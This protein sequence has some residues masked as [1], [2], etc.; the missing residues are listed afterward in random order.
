MANRDITCDVDA[1]AASLEQLIGDIPQA[2]GD[3]TEKAVG[4]SVRKGAKLLRGR[5]TEGIGKHPW[6]AEY[7]GGFS[8][9]V[10]RAGLSTEG[11][12]GNKAKPG[13]VHL[14]EKGHAT[15]NGRRTGKFEHMDPAFREV[16]EDFVERVGK[17]VGEA[18]R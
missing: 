6:S 16:Q 9:R 5:Y 14:L 7:R 12:I 8:S 3:A 1:F 13:L 17:A 11:R 15:L 18:L 2:C 4:Q 10:K